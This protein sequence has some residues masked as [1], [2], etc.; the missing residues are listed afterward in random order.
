MSATPYGTDP[1]GT[2]PPRSLP[3]GLAVASLVLGILGLA[4]S[5]LVI[6]G[7]LGLVALILG[8]VA[9]GKIKRGEAGGRG[10]ALGGII[11]GI[12]AMLVTL[13]IIVT[14]GAFFAENKDEIGNLTDCLEQANNNQTEIQACQDEFERQVNP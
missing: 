14:V 11:T 7:L 4:G 12:L 6:G 3:T 8:I 13:L 5:V 1:Y 10:M 9:L 2:A